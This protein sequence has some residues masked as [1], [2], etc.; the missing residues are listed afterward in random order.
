MNDWRLVPFAAALLA[1]A[2]PAQAAEPSYTVAVELDRAP[3]VDVVRFYAKL[4]D[5]NFVVADGVYGERVTILAG[6]PV[7]REEAWDAFLVVMAAQRV[8]VEEVG[9]FWVLK[10]S[11]TRR[12][13]ARVG[14]PDESSVERGEASDPACPPTPDVDV[15][16]TGTRYTLERSAVDAWLANYDIAVYYAPGDTVEDRIAS[17][18]ERIQTVLLS[19]HEQDN[20]IYASNVTPGVVQRI[21]G[22]LAASVNVDIT[23]RL[24]GI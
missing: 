19:L 5:R 3:L 13:P 6:K 8:D 15:D 22:A 24:T 20:D 18:F 21:E 11:A 7:T 9:P 14:A 23:Y 17:D 1:L 16:E 10:R 4:L 2:T 12:R